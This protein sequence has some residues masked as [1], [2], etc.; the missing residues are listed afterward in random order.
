MIN[1]NNFS[2]IIDTIAAMHQQERKTQRCSKYFSRTT[3]VDESSRTAMMNWL[4]QISDALSLNRETVGIAMS[5]LDRF[6]STSTKCAEQTLADRHK[7]Q[8]ASITAY[9]IAIKINEPVQLGI[10]M[11]VK[12][13]RGFYEPSAILNMEKDILFSLEWRI[14]APTALDFMRHVLALLPSTE[15]CIVEN[16]ERNLANA[17]KDYHFS[18][19][20]PS[21]V[22][23]ACVAVSFRES[24]VCPSTE[25]TAIWSEICKTLGLD[26]SSDFA[27]AQQQLQSNSTEKPSPVGRAI[28]TLTRRASYV[29]LGESSSPVAV[30]TSI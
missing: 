8:L 27:G 14:S 23:A 26:E 12:L 2:D 6:L 17:T 30:N 19:L 25:Q 9:Y 20:A 7:F 28:T 11:L 16:A 24:Y 15:Q 21:A 22:G 29:H 5:L 18:S 13:C 3:V 1:I 4:C 10:D